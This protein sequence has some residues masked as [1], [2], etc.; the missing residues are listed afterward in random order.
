MFSKLKN[1]FTA[2]IIVT[3]LAPGFYFGMQPAPKA[4]ADMAGIIGDI[5]GAGVS[6]VMCEYGDE[7]MGALGDLLGGAIEGLFG[8]FL[9]DFG[10]ILGF[11]DDKD[12]DGTGD[13]V[14]YKVA[15][16]D[17][18]PTNEQN[19]SVVLNTNSIARGTE[20]QVY[21]ECVLDPAAWVVKAILVNTITQDILDWVNG[22][23]YDGPVFLRDPIEFMKNL[24]ESMLFSFL[25]DSGLAD[26]LCTPFRDYTIDFVRNTATQPTFSKTGFSSASCNFGELGGESNYIAMVEDGD[27]LSAGLTAA[28]A[29]TLEGNNPYSA[30]FNVQDEASQRVDQIVNQQMTR[31]QYSDGYFSMDCD[32][33]GTVDTC[34]P[35]QLVSKQVDDW[36]GGSLSELENADEI[37]EIIDAAISYMVHSIFSDSSTDGLLEGGRFDEEYN[38]VTGG[39]IS[40]TATGGTPDNTNTTFLW[41]PFSSATGKLEVLLPSTFVDTCKVTVQGSLKTE[42]LDFIGR[43]NGNRPT[44]RGDFAGSLYG[45]PVKVTASC[46]TS[47]GGNTT[48]V[49]NVPNAAATFTK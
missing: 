15:F 14:D 27:I 18:V 39:E 21:K 31:V 11:G 35:G 3:L 24:A 9:G 43:T 29:I 32:Y 30:V 13:G 26:A 20:T 49:W 12:G 44:Y 41:K 45:S 17:A 2:L 37:G 34:T 19:K 8:D 4:E 23:F 6:Y 33:N 38:P 16:Q 42:V 22:G 28:A 48:T 46:P 5:V 7:L 1:S 36:L 10:S 47:G 40:D 25:E